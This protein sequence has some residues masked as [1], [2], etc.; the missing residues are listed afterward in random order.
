M[1]V[2]TTL[3]LSII[4]K[5]YETTLEETKFEKGL[6]VNI[7]P[8]LNF[9]NHIKLTIKKQDVLSLAYCMT[10]LAIFCLWP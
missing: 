5:G 9:N 6:G 2:V 7:D 1:Y 10:T 8:E 3:Y 4:S